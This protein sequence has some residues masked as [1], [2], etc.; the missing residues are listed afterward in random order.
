MVLLLLCIISD[1]YEVTVT[2]AMRMSKDSDNSSSVVMSEL[3]HVH[4]QHLCTLL[5]I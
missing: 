3:S 4:T 2:S 5:T 1:Y